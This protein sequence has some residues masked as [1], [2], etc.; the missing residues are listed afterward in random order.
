MHFGRPGCFQ[1]FGT[2]IEGGP[3]GI[4]IV[5]DE[6]A[7]VFHLVGIH[8]LEGILDIMEALFAI[9]ARLRLR[10]TRSEKRVER[11]RQPQPAA[12]SPGKQ[13]RLVKAAMSQP[14]Y[15]KRN[16]TD[17]LHRRGDCFPPDQAY[18]QLSQGRGPVELPA[19]FQLVNPLANHTP[20]VSC[21]TGAVKE[22]NRQ[23]AVTAQMIG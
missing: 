3:G 12:E 17:H 14:L 21:R 13:S 20:M 9:E 15:M 11:D 7:T 19:E 10:P 16:R 6:D 23:K 4:D 5:H 22:K 2:F 18:Q 1:G 8:H